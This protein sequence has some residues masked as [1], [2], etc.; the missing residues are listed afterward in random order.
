ML[1]CLVTRAEIFFQSV[2]ELAHAKAYHAGVTRVLERPLS[3]SLPTFTSSCSVVSELSRSFALAAA[4][5]HCRPAVL[6]YLCNLSLSGR[7]S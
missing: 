3:E 4:V 5:A 2:S 1:L 6:W 7:R